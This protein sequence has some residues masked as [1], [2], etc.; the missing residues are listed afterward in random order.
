MAFALPV[1]LA[2]QKE[3]LEQIHVD[4]TCFDQFDD[5]AL[6][7]VFSPHQTMYRVHHRRCAHPL[8]ENR[9]EERRTV[10]GRDG[11]GGSELLR[12]WSCLPRPPAEGWTEPGGLPRDPQ[13]SLRGLGRDVRCVHLLPTVP[14]CQT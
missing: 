12:A 7:L 9:P 5:G 11:H 6:F 13:H 14:Q 3:L 10:R 8:K 2:V 4:P 1:W